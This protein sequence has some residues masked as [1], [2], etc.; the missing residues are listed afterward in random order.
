MPRFALLPPKRRSSRHAD[1]EAVYSRYYGF[2]RD[3]LRRLGIPAADL[4]DVT[5]EVFVV[6]LRKLDEHDLNGATR[7]WLFQVARRVAS[8]DRRKRA[9]EQRK[10]S[11]DWRALPHVDPEVEAQRLEAAR[12]LG[13]FLGTLGDADR[14][15]FV[16][17]E[18]EGMTGAAIAERVGLNVNTTYSR[19]RTLRRRFHDHAQRHR[20]RAPVVVPPM[21]LPG[22]GLVWALRRS[23]SSTRTWLGLALLALLALALLGWLGPRGGGGGE[24]PWGGSALPIADGSAGS[25]R[26]DELDASS[27]IVL[28]DFSG[29]VVDGDGRPIHGAVVCGDRSLGADHILVDRPRCASTDTAGRFH[30]ARVLDQG[31]TIEVMARGFLPVRVRTRPGAPIRLVMRRGGVAVRGVVEDVY[32]GPIAGAWVSRELSAEPTL[33][34]TVTT[35]DQGRFELWLEPGPITI[36]AGADGYATWFSPTLAPV[37]A[38]EVQ[39]GAE[40]IVSGTV[41]DAKGRPVAD[42]KVLIGFMARPGTLPHNHGGVTWSRQDGTFEARNLQPGRY[43]VDV[44]SEA[45]YGRSAA[46]L[47]LGF[48]ERRDGIVI[49]L[50]PGATIHG[51]VVDDRTG[52]ACEEGFVAVGEPE[53][54]ITRDV[55]ITPGGAVEVAGLTAGMIHTVTVACRGYARRRFAVDL[56]EGSIGEQ[57]WAVRPGHDVRGRILDAE[58]EPV[59]GWNVSLTPPEGPDYS[60]HLPN[61]VETNVDGEFAFESVAS[62]SYVLKAV[63]RGHPHH[64]PEPVRVEAGAAPRPLEIRLGRGFTVTGRVRT[65]DGAPLISALVLLHDPTKDAPQMPYSHNFNSARVL[66]PRPHGPLESL[67]LADGRFTI[68]GV[69]PGRYG[70]WVRRDG[71][72]LPLRDI[73]DQRLPQGEPL[74]WVVIDDGPTPLELELPAAGGSITGVVLDE[75]GSPVADA[76]VAA[77]EVGAP[78]PAPETLGSSSLTDTSGE[79]TLSGLPDGRYRVMAHRRGGGTAV[80]PG[81]DLGDHVTLRIPTTGSLAGTVKNDEGELVNAFMISITGEGSQ[82]NLPVAATKGRWLLDGVPVGTYELEVETDLGRG[83]RQVTLE[84]G[85]H[86]EDIELVAA[87]EPAL[88]GVL[89]DGDTSEPADGWIVAAYRSPTASMA[90]YATTTRPDGSFTLAFLPA[91][92]IVVRAASS[93]PEAGVVVA[94]T[95]PSAGAPQDL[96]ELR[97]RATDRAEP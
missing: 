54:R 15:V 33:G 77:V 27:A 12:V 10:R 61:H 9:R 26:R 41:V 3:G 68:E 70:V 8:H 95:T 79:F 92:P 39:L 22:P 89:V 64:G 65:D 55:R 32:G 96:G 43:V 21:W 62:G 90:V 37:D 83:R 71:S 69:Q 16:A 58:G 48:G 34:A 36:A 35:D 42:A 82:R 81:V 50:V 47:D 20:G 7:S 80:E 87:R 4:D 44:A 5:Q 30:I 45:G 49:E 88:V 40:S 17:S 86:L 84:A 75:G 57:T 24:P 74:R 38:L 59:P 1:F 29:E 2:V 18:V 51:R 31:H 11:M 60:E 72:A 85:Q 63:G 93:R 46:E 19:I 52:A 14:A 67:T 91:A 25:E 13:D 6:L 56:R 66:I 97:V 76:G 23:G 28:P 94:T 73:L 53:L 78:A